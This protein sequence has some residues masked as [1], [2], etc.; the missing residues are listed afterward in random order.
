MQLAWDRGQRQAFIL[1]VPDRRE[2][3]DVLGGLLYN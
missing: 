2:L 1:A 3:A